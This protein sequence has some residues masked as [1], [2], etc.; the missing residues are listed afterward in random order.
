[1]IEDLTSLSTI[2]AEMSV[3]EVNEGDNANENEQPGIV[4]LSLLLEGIVT[5][6]VAVGLIMDLGVLFESLSQ[7]ITGEHMAMTKLC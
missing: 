7:S 1:M 2:E 3:A 6:L 5:K 4:S